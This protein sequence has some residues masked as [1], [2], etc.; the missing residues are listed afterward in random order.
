[1][2]LLI[3]S[4]EILRKPPPPKLMY[5]SFYPGNNKQNVEL[6][7]A[8]YQETN[9]A[10]CQSHFPERPD[11]DSFLN[12]LMCRSLISNSIKRCMP[13]TLNNAVTPM[14]IEN[15]TILLGDRLQDGK[16]VVSIDILYSKTN[17]E[18]LR[19]N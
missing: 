6:T 1:M 14:E 8:I 12:L 5:S 9:V 3:N 7:I 13:N 19:C 17:W 11:V 15:T 16:F 18:G 2:T 4:T 10:V